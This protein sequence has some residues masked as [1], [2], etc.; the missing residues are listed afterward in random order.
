MS[1]RSPNEGWKMCLG[2]LGAGRKLPQPAPII[3]AESRLLNDAPVLSALT[4]G[5]QVPL[6]RLFSVGLSLSHFESLLWGAK[7]SLSNG[8]FVSIHQP[9]VG[10]RRCVH[11]H[12]QISKHSAWL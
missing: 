9:W 2:L 10:P 8:Y 1:A 4:L 3:T 5:S 6:G 7:A 11:F 12:T